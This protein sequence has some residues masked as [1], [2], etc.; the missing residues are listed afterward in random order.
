MY[1]FFKMKRSLR[2]SEVRNCTAREQAISVA[3]REITA[4]GA[5]VGVAQ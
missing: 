2:K 3:S 5:T 4:S 1:L